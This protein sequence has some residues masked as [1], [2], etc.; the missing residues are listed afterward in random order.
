MKERTV[1]R[2]AI[3]SN[4][5]IKIILRNNNYILMLHYIVESWGYYIKG[6]VHIIL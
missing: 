2:M 5:F 3:G 6:C 4:I 1:Y